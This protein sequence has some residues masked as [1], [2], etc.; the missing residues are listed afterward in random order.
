MYID[1][2]ESQLALSSLM[3]RG[4]DPYL[5]IKTTS[6][7]EEVL[8]HCDEY[9]VIVTDYVMPEI[10][11]VHL[12]K[13]I[14]EKFSTPII[15]YTGQGGQEVAEAAFL[16]GVDDYIRKEVEAAHYQVF[17]QRIRVAAERYRV[18]Y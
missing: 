12:A 3:L 2:D 13:K 18:Q 1:D 9:D 16:V 14:R 15:I 4:V 8:S 17:A 11:G 5:D 6:D 10:D 7:P